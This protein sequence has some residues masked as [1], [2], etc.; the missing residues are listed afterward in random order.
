MKSTTTILLALFMLLSLQACITPRLSQHNNMCK[1]DEKMLQNQQSSKKTQENCHFYGRNTPYDRK[2]QISIQSQKLTD[3]SSTIQ[4]SSHADFIE[5]FDTPLLSIGDRLSINVLNGDEFSGNVEINADGFIYL[6]YLPPLKAQGVSIALLKTNIKQLL[7]DEQLMINNAIR[8]SIVPLKW[9][10]IQVSVSGAVFEP[11]L[12]KINHKSDTEITDDSGGHSGDQAAGRSVYMAL[13][14]SGGISPNANIRNITITRGQRVIDIDLSGVINGNPVPHLT[15]IAEDHIH[16][17]HNTHFDD[18]LA[19]P[20]QITVPGIRVFISN[21]TQPATS[22]SQSAVDTEATRF[23]YGSRLLT[24]V[25]GG[26]CVGGAQSTSAGRHV[27]LIT[28][29]PLTQKIDVIERSIDNLIAQSWQSDMNPILLPGDGIACYDSG[30][31]NLREIA[32]TLREIIVPVT[33]LGI[34]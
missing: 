31:T 10:P 24:G 34:L 20:S 18:S 7:I 13:K 27:L 8:L 23:P 6:P 9:A 16:V 1:D 11:G 12:H 30:I 19:R 2:K 33:L 32:R 5:S 25:I 4:P 22:N 21:L 3:E 29:N 15:L 17:P 28:K 14:A 26:N